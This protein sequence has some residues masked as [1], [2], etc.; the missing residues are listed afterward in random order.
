MENRPYRRDFTV[1]LEQAGRRLDIFLSEKN[2]E[3]SRNIFQHLIASKKVLV[4]GRNVNKSHIL[5]AGD[6]IEFEIPLQPTISHAAQDIPIK[7]IYQDRYLA[8]ISKPAGMVV[9]PAPGHPNGTLV[10]AILYQLKDM[11]FISGESRPGIVHRLDKDTSGLLVVGKNE[12][13]VSKLIEMM[14]ARDVTKI[15]AALVGGHV[16]PIRG[17]VDRGIGRNPRNRLRMK[18]LAD[19]REAKTH[20][21]VVT[22]FDRYDLLKILIKSGRTHQIR[23]HMNYMGHPV[24]GDAIYGGMD[25]NT[26][27]FGLYRQFLHSCFIGFKH[28]FTGKSVA[29][30]DELSTEL[31]EFLRKACNYEV[32]GIR[33]IFDIKDQNN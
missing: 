5:S 30:W 18:V 6:E 10:N 29:V 15:Y 32:H 13:A 4:N 9:H 19:G 3:I 21:E 25:D 23:V 26:R 12:F 27:R 11:S 28:P 31:V 20:Y 1:N 7:I 24:V 2:P 16:E 8:V 33:A 14:R 17:E 22:R